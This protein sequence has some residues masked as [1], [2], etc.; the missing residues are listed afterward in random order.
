MQRLLHRTLA[1]RLSV[2]VD[3]NYHHGSFLN[4]D[5]TMANIILVDQRISLRRLH[6]KAFNLTSLDVK[7]TFDSISHHFIRY[8]LERMGID[9]RRVH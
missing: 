3:L 1:K 7:K 5:G 8:A 2:S 9:N 4:I 6:G